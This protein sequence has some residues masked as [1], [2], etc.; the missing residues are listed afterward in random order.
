MKD[1]FKM[2]F[3]ST[4]G[5]FI[6]MLV[7]GI[8]S[9]AVMIGMISSMASSGKQT[10]TIQKN[11]VMELDL[12]GSISDRVMENPFAA[13]YGMT[14][15]KQLSL[16]DILDAIK[17]AEE[18]ENIKG[19]YI[20]GGILQAGTPTIEAIRSALIDFKKSGKFV[21][22]YGGTFSQG[23]YYLAT[24]ADKVILNPQGIIDLHGLA[25]MPMFYKGLMDKIGIKMEIFKVGT[26]KSAVEPYMLDKMSDANREQV[27]SYMG[28]LW[29]NISNNIATSRN[30]DQATLNGLVNEGILLKG[31]ENILKAGL[32]DTLLY[33]TEASDYIKGLI[34]VDKKEKLKTA[35]VTQ[36]K[37]SPFKV[38]SDHKE[39]IAVLFAE[40]EITTKPTGAFNTES[41]ISDK[42]YVEEL[43]KL[44]DDENVKAVVFRVNSPGGSAYMSEQIWK[45]VVELKKEKP[46]VVSMGNYAASGGYYISCGADWIVAEP[47]TLTG[48]IG[49]FGMVPTVEKLFD[50]IGLGHDVVKT[51]QFA[52]FGD[53]SR[54][55]RDDEKVLMQSYIEKGYDLFIS[56]CAEGRGKTKAE[57]DS[58]GQGR[59]WTGEQALAR[60]L[61]DE[62]G[63]LDKAIEV[64]AK[65]AELETYSIKHYPAQ[66]D[67]FALLLEES[68]AEVKNG[69]VKSL[70]N[71]NEFRHFTFLKNIEVQ[72]YVQARLP[73]DIEIK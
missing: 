18:N 52:D 12:N 47:T 64:A 51:N 2:L 70:L 59:V 50:N 16:V 46:V 69:L 22:A 34:D 36:L 41:V 53:I 67:F 19:I 73:F 24:A 56:R 5:V 6:A 9:F 66:K 62:L 27:T 45:E 48:S 25:A 31:A 17:K 28:S 7:I 60:G 44:K 37:Q 4:I 63:G 26:F 65:K 15:T 10:V 68:F 30:M 3:A 29:N 33:S 20:K 32:V 49:I 72:D 14:E 55:M 57:I 54:S 40:G 39:Q 58:I 1:F 71:E 21:V 42:E 35:N 61:V 13:F 43:R 8:I 11:T 38:K 23:A